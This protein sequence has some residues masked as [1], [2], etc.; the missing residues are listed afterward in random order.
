MLQTEV[1]LAKMTGEA[2]KA[3]KKLVLSTPA[4]NALKKLKAKILR[5]R[6][7]GGL[8]PGPYQ[9]DIQQ[10]FEYNGMEY[11]FDVENVRGHNLRK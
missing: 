3:N 9:T 4:Q 6:E 5:A 10:L 1:A 7:S 2:A 11:R 8:V